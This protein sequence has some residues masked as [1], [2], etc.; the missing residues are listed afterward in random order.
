[1]EKISVVVITK[2]EERNLEVCLRSVSFA[3]EIII[4]DA[5]SS[6]KTVK[7]A[8]K[9]T[10]NVFTRKWDNFANQ[11]NYGIDR[12]KND[13][14]L[15]LDADERVSFALREELKNLK[16]LG[17]GYA[18]P[19]KNYFLG[20]WM[21]HGGQY[22]DYHLRLFNRRKGRFM[23][24]VRQVHEGVYLKEGARER[25]LDNCLEHFSYESIYS[26]IRKFNSYTYLDARGR[27]EKGVSP[28]IYGI[29]FRPVHRFFKWYFLQLGM[30]DGIHG[31]I[32]HSL[33]AFYYFTCELKLLEMNG[34]NPKAF[35]WRT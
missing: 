20:K 30:L 34:Y 13:W 21:K 10:K 31:L 17:E 35:K 15:S 5:G 32:F 22:P 16:P 8:Q 1:M 6:D 28:S 14:V 12:A 3:N 24:N 29:I 25:R 26:Y 9:F 4:V 33:S 23:F 11:K 27:S 2:N 18:F 7:I 19:I